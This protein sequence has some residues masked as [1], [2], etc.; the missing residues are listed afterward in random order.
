MKDD[1]MAVICRGHARTLEDAAVAWKADH[2]D[3]GRVAIAEH[4]T[5]ACLLFRDL[6]KGWQ[7]D[8]WRRLF[9]GQL[10]DVQRV[11]EL[12]REAYG[13]ILARFDAI[14]PDVDGWEARECVL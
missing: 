2:E 13:K 11:G 14:A 6:M 10:H 8:A 4:L 5:A 9:A 1:V 12:L 3:A 7:K